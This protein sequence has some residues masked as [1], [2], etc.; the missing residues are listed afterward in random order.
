[1]DSGEVYWNRDFLER[2]SSH[3]GYT[4]QSPEVLRVLE[5]E[6]REAERRR[7][8]YRG[9]LPPLQAA[10]KTVIVVDDGIATG[11][12]MRAALLSLAHLGAPHI[13]AAVP[14][15]SPRTI[16]ELRAL[17]SDVV[18]LLQPSN[19]A[20]V[21]QHYEHFEQTEDA[22]VRDCMRRE[23][24]R[25]RAQHGPSAAV[26]SPTAKTE[27]ATATPKAREA[28]DTEARKEARGYASGRQV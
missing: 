17:A 4:Q 5:R 7:R 6:K 24:E 22:E 11:A 18:C 8:V 21:G 20:A 1:M 14:V 10:G 27:N 16:R 15:G 26:S 9:E 12:T 2:G 25:R 13:V 23:A 28:D 3:Y 19:F